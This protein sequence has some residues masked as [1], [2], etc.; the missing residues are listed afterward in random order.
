MQGI[1]PRQILALTF[2]NK[3]AKE[4]KDRLGSKGVRDVRVSTFHAICHMVL[5]EFH[6][7]AGFPKRPLIWSSKAELRA[8][9]AEAMR[10]AHTV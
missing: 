9:L 7:E 4:L 1:S 3:A 6:A 10:C 2:T 5:A 8:V